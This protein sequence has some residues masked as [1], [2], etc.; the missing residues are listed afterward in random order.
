MGT[1]PYTD[2]LKVSDKELFFLTGCSN[3]EEGISK[4]PKSPLI[5]VTLGSEGCMYQFNGKIGTIPALQCHPVDTTGAGD[6]FVSGILYSL[7]EASRS[8]T[9]LQESEISEMI[10][11]SSISGG[12]ATTKKGAMTGLPT[13]QEIQALL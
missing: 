8:L 5:L 3:I 11:F 7:N 10:R 4:L 6:A 12:L 13:L 1:I 2:V 9:E